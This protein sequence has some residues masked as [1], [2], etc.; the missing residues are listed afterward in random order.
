MRRGVVV[1]ATLALVSVSCGV[2]GG[3]ANQRTIFV[4]FSHD[5][6]NSFFLFNFPKKVDVHPGTTLVFRQT[7]TGEPHTVTGGTVV[8]EKVAGGRPLIEWFESFEALMAA[9]GRLSVWMMI[10]GGRREGSN[11]RALLRRSQRLA[12]AW[13][14]ERSAPARQGRCGRSA[15]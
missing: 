15:S 7:W 3:G 12:P 10:P 5:E 4:D 2:L 14:S 9:D 8:D 11:R 1:A 6:F 13:L